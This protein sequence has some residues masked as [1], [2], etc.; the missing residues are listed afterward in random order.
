MPFFQTKLRPEDFIVTEILQH[1]PSWHG[2]Y[3]YIMIEKKWLTTFLLIDLLIKDFWFNRNMI[4]IA[5]LKDKNAITRQWISI[6]KRDIAKYVWWVNDLLERLRKKGRVVQATYWESMLKLGDNAG[7]HFDLTLVG[8]ALLS[9]AQKKPL[10]EFMDAIPSKWI[11]NFFG[12]QRFGYGWSNW[13]IWHELL[14]WVIRNIKWDKNTLAEKRFKVQAF[15]SYVF[16]QYIIERDKK[17]ALYKTIPWD[18]LGKDKKSITWPVPWDDLKL[19]TQDAGKLEKYVFAKVGL[20]PQLFDRFKIFGLFG[21]RRPLLVFPGKIK[22][23]WR[24]KILFLS[25]DLPS[26]AY[27]TVLIDELEKILRANWVVVSDKWFKETN[28]KAKTSKASSWFSA[29]KDKKSQQKITSVKKPK[30]PS[31]N[32]YTGQKI[33]KDKAKNRAERT[34]KKQQKREA[35]KSK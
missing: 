24:G 23:T 5:W 27:A 21:I 33:N 10:E 9:D 32:P 35:R 17:W 28:T 30:D 26:G 8:S 15:A 3:H 1:E 7:N 16:N 13:K 20:T 22:Y 25:F 6:A 18:I 31:I 29:T 19:S 12:D 11:P 4:G 34:A 14:A 2:E